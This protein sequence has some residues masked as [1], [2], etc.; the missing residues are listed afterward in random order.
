MA[1]ERISPNELKVDSPIFISHVFRYRLAKGLLLP[2]DSVIDF[3]CGCG[4]G[5]KILSKACKEILGVDIAKGAVLKEYF[6]SNMK[7]EVADIITLEKIKN[8]DVG[9][10]FEILEH[11]KNPA[12]LVKLLKTAKRLIIMSVPNKKTVGKKGNPYHKRDFSKKDI[13]KLFIDEEWELFQEVTQ[14]V[15][16][17]FIFYRKSNLKKEDVI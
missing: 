15:Y 5:T 9:V 10:A 8:Y 14:N 1:Y 7:F 4:Y 11:L 17:I 16:S 12:P 13:L 6:S 3:G 2:T